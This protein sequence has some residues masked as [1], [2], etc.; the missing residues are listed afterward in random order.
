MTNPL[1][2]L[3]LWLEKKLYLEH[4]LAITSD[5][6]QKFALRKQIQE[7][8]L[9]IARLSNQPPTQSNP[10]TYQFS[11]SNQPAQSNQSNVSAS[12]Q[13][14]CSQENIPKITFNTPK[15][16][17]IGVDKLK[18]VISKVQILLLTVNEWERKAL[19]SEMTPLD[20]EESILQGALSSITYRIGMFGNYCAAYTESTMGSLG[21]QGATLTTER[22]INELKPKAVFLLGIAFGID[23]NKQKLGDVL[24]AE[25]IF[26]YELQKLN[27]DFA[28]HRGQSVPCGHTL[29]ERFRMRRADWK[30]IIDGKLIEVNVH[31]GLVLS[32]EKVINNKEFKDALVKEFPTAIGGEME[33]AGAYSAVNPPTEVILIKSICDWADGSKDD[34]AQPFAAFTAVSLAKY[35][36]SKP[37]VLHPLIKKEVANAQP[38][39][40]DKKKEKNELTYKDYEI[41]IEQ[42]IKPANSHNQDELC[43]C[44]SG[45]KYSL[46]HGI[47]YIFP[48]E[49]HSPLKTKERSLKERN[50]L[51]VDAVLDIFGAKRKIPWIKVRQ[52]ISGNQ[53]RELYEVIA[54]LWPLNTNIENLL[55]KSDNKLR[56]LYSGDVSPVDIVQNVSRFGLYADELMIIDPFHN[57]H[58]WRGEA[59]PIET[60]DIYKADTLKLVYFIYMLEPWIKADLVKIIPNPA[61]FDQQLS[62]QFVGMANKRLKKTGLD[63]ELEKHANKMM[64]SESPEFR[65]IA[66]SQPDSVLEKHIREENPNYS[67]DEIRTVLELLIQKRN[68]DP[69]ALLQPLQN[70]MVHGFRSGANLE[71]FLFISHLT[72]GFPFTNTPFKWK[73]ILSQQKALNEDAKIWIPL[74]KAFQELEF[75]FLNSVDPKFAVEMRQEGRLEHFRTFLRKIWD[76]TNRDLSNNSINSTIRNYKDELMSEYNTAQ[77]DWDKI[78]RDL[79][80]WGGS[81]TI[82]SLATATSA[83]LTGN[84]ALSIPAIALSTYGLLKV[85]TSRME[86]KEFKKKFPMAVF[87]DLNNK[88]KKI[89]L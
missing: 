59:N 46:C 58:H 20:G 11:Q 50:L 88:N 36:L 64:G 62:S 67:E 19:L 3:Q 75:K 40:K 52:E 65:R 39:K 77:S 86:K 13:H 14:Q 85:V 73:E 17:D 72:G 83:I 25:S 15:I 21:R 34:N 24:I 31:Q 43:S 38:S 10:T 33:G 76:S 44:G 55:P 2:P 87:V 27:N 32:G 8:E 82:A 56:G 84:M 54:D 70:G 71:T 1:N 49:N 78:T 37:D 30:P 7:C 68:N 48:P 12:Q 18:D 53:V 74:T 80:L 61:S 16:I 51:L 35:V 5:A 28:I 69:V 57:P 4:Q 47:F 23:S 26:P 9:E 45:K 79:A 41:L 42:F 89:T 63:K 60:P 81:A 6:S 66:L 22:V 29:S